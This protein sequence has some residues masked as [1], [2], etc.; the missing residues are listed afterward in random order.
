MQEE[1]NFFLSWATYLCCNNGTMHPFIHLSSIPV[2]LCTV[3]LGVSPVIRRATSRGKDM[4]PFALTHIH[5]KRE[6]NLLYMHVFWAE[7]ESQRTS[8]GHMEAPSLSQT[9]HLAVLWQYQLS[10]AS[11]DHSRLFE[12][13]H[14]SSIG[15]SPRPSHH[16]A[17]NL[18]YHHYDNNDVDVSQAPWSV[19]VSRI[20]PDFTSGG[21]LCTGNKL[22]RDSQMKGESRW[23]LSPQHQWPLLCGRRP[24]YTSVT[25]IAFGAVCLCV[26]LPGWVKRS[27]CTM[28]I[29]QSSFCLTRRPGGTLRMKSVYNLL[30][31]D[32][33]G[34]G[35]KETQYDK[36]IRLTFGQEG[37]QQI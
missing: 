6:P 25:V 11:T 14:L 13:I 27:L 19:T 21:V 34:R 15:A 18:C 26:C 5:T 10:V 29:R 32:N 20:M 7:R 2:P 31:G 3:D 12:I 16:M 35:K 24:V 4:R 30:C 8:H 33:T 9:C 37:C 36:M 22:E 17:L 23:I 1:I 28:S